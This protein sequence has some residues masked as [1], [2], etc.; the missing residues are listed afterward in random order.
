[1]SG[2]KSS[3]IELNRIAEQ[4]LQTKR[5]KN[6]AFEIIEELSNRIDNIISKM[7]E[8]LTQNAS[9][10]NL[11]LE[12]KE[13]LKK[14]AINIKEVKK[15]LQGILIPELTR[16]VNTQWLE[17]THGRILQLRSEIQ[18]ICNVFDEIEASI[19]NLNVADKSLSII[20]I[21]IQ[22]Y[23]NESQNHEKML[24]KWM[25]SE[26]IRS[27]Q[28]NENLQNE[29]LHYKET[30]HNKKDSEQITKNFK[31]IEGVFNKLN[32]RLKSLVQEAMHKEELHQRR[33]Y[34][35]KGLREVCRSIGFEEASEPKY[36]IE[37]DYNSPILQSFDTLNKGNFKIKLHLHNR[38]E[39]DSGIN[40]EIC[41]DEFGKLSGL[42]A[43]EFG[44]LTLF[45]RVNQE[46]SP[47]RITKKYKSQ[48]K[49]Q[50]NEKESS[51]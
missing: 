27:N 16:D 9:I 42:L 5:E 20:E 48:Q 32:S 17:A 38:I 40:Q 22:K 14:K 3:D 7:S 13:L 15:E 19:I 36:E 6:V 25:L 2:T 18:R 47:K 41:D 31:E 51:K 34:I 10:A 29:L 33:L 44:V 30:L 46:D 35:L 1:M 49:S 26:Y 37:G 28:D 50:E 45:K 11:F 21:N 39:S 12:N 24:K 8:V 4:L 23:Q 43:Q